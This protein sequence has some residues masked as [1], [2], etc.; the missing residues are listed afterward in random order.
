[1]KETELDLLNEQELTVVKDNSKRAK[2]LILVFW[3]FIGIT[4]LASLTN[5]TTIQNLRKAYQGEQ[6]SEQAALRYELISGAV[7]LLKTGL[8][9]TTIVVFLN[10]FRRAYGN[11]HR[12]GIPYLRYQE[13]M[14]VW[15]WFIPIVWFYRPVRIMLEIWAET[16]E[17]I[18][19]YDATYVIKSGGLL[20]GVW[21]TFNVV[22]NIADNIIFRNS[23]KTLTQEELIDNLELSMVTDLLKIPEALLVILI[24]Y[25]VSKMEA[26]LLV[27]VRNAHET[28]NTAQATP[29]L[30]A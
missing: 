12:V 30:E 29:V 28:A 16:Q 11:L 10:W 6:L 15:A 23:F 5:Y 4:L 17:K 3:A 1:M 20:I 2:T 26:R 8:L 25:M 9:I 19:M 22:L 21:W 18:K 7:D 24:V 13:S 14:A 27:K